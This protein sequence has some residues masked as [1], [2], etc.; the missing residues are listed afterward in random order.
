MSLFFNFSALWFCQLPIP[1]ITKALPHWFSF[2]WGY[3]TEILDYILLFI[4]KYTLFI[5]RLRGSGLRG[6]QGVI[7]KTVSDDLQ[8]NIWD[9]THMDKIVP[10]LLYNMQAISPWV[11]WD[12]GGI[13]IWLTFFRWHFQLHFVELK[14]LLVLMEISLLCSWWSDCQ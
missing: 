8:T 10:S 2:Q 4:H 6:I 3:L 9:H 5:C 7:R 1:E 11:L 13:T 12:I 14:S